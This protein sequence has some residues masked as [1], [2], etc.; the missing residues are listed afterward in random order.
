MKSATVLELPWPSPILSPNA[1]AHWA[2]RARAVKSYRHTCKI[3]TRH[4]KITAPEQ[5]QIVIEYEFVRPAR[6]RFDDDGLVSRMKAGRDGIADALGIDDHRFISK[7]F[8][9]EEVVKDGLVRVRLYAC[10]GGV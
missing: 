8:I 5:G 9:S 2:K 6:Y 10:E 7:H 1:R 4:A 3:L